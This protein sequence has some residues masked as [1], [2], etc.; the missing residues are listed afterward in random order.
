MSKKHAR[1][2]IKELLEWEQHMY[3]PGYYV[4]RFSPFFPPKPSI[5]TWILT[6]ID[7]FLSLIAA[8]AMTWLRLLSAR[9]SWLSWQQ[10]PFCLLSSPASCCGG[11]GHLIGSLNKDSA[12]QMRMQSG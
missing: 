10:S 1:D 5:Y 6:L 9:S 12:P 4:N 8:T 2:A 11:C 7:F 3:T